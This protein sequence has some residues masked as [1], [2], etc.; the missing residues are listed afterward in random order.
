MAAIVVH[1]GKIVGIGA[2]GNRANSNSITYWD[3]TKGWVTVAVNDQPLTAEDKFHLGSNSKSITATMIA[4]LVQDGRFVNGW[5][6]QVSEVFTN[7]PI[8]SGFRDATLRQL[9]AHRTGLPWAPSPDF[10]DVQFRLHN[11][12][13]PLTLTELQTLRQTITAQELAKNPASTPGG[14]V[15]SNLG[16]VIAAHMAEVVMNQPWETL[17]QTYLFTPLGMTS[18]GFGPPG[19]K[20]TASPCTPDQPWGHDANGKTWLPGDP[21]SD[22]APMSGPAGNIHMSLSD[23]ATYANM[24]L[25]ALEG[26][27]TY[28]TQSTLE[29]LHI[30][31]A[32]GDGLNYAG[33]WWAVNSPYDAN[34]R[35]SILSF[36]AG[37]GD[38]LTH[39]G[40]NLK[41]YATTSIDATKDLA[42]LVVTTSGGDLAN[43]AA[44]AAIAKLYD[45]P[46][47]E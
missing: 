7:I 44:W 24:H 14:F 26:N 31:V 37:V 16:I 9:L 6:T 29:S 21:S 39:D 15:Y 27:P 35:R 45:Y 23:W 20:C 40:S 47:P 12:Y 41:W 25:K 18:A 33:G 11:S 32:Y 38:G 17:V 36:V 13:N 3:T 5:N 30:P 34:A 19:T 2:T 28:L 43:R 1:N 4:K 8:S 10:W 42:I 46:W 22:N